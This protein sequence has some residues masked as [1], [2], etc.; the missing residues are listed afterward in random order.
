L[1]GP[2]TDF[3]Q[4]LNQ[5]SARPVLEQLQRASLQFNDECALNDC[6]RKMV[7]KF[8]KGEQQIIQVGRYFFEID[9]EAGTYSYRGV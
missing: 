5:A 4:V 7:M 3:E 1:N 8:V 6:E 9:P 2:S